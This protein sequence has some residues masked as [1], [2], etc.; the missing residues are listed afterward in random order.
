[1]LPKPS[2]VKNQFY[3]LFSTCGS[4]LLSKTTKI[5]R[6][7][8]IVIQVSECVFSFSVFMSLITNHGKFTEQHTLRGPGRVDTWHSSWLPRI[9]TVFLGLGNFLRRQSSPSIPEAEF[10]Y[11]HFKTSMQ[12]KCG[13]MKPSSVSQM[14]RAET[15][16]QKP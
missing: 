1:M 3:V 15:L 4:V 9:S 6:Q 11:L 10:S 12:L 7:C 2:V 14:R 16:N 8:Q 5:L 13:H